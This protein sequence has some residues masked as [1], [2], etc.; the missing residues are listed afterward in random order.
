MKFLKK[1]SDLA[2][3]YMPIISPLLDYELSCQILDARK[4]QCRQVRARP[5]VVTPRQALVPKRSCRF[6]LDR[7]RLNRP[8][9]L[10]SLPGR[11]ADVQLCPRHRGRR[12]RLR[13][14]LL[15][16]QRP[17]VV[18]NS[19]EAGQRCAPGRR[20]DTTSQRHAWSADCLAVVSQHVARLGPSFPKTY[21]TRA[22]VRTNINLDKLTPQSHAGTLRSSADFSLNR[23]EKR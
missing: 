5:G 22:R 13:P 14:V 4:D 1:G 21:L 9:H 8:L 6:A 7:P 17:Q 20:Q 2:E 11:L 12:P 19:R 23:T 18:C 10:A 3:T 15:G 16:R